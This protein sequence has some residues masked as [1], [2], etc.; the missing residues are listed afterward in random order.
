MVFRPYPVLTLLTLPALALLLALG[1][2]QVERMGWKRDLIA[3]Y[4]TARADPADDL[5]EAICSIEPLPGRPVAQVPEPGGE[6]SVRLYG[7]DGAG[8]PGWRVFRPADAPSCL[9]A[10]AILIETG[11]EPINDGEP[12]DV[13]AWRIERPPEAGPFTPA[14]DPANAEFY[15]FEAAPIAAA[16]GRSS[17]GL[18]REWLL[19]ADDGALPA[20]LSQTPPERHF[21]Y[22]ATW[23]G[24]AITLVAVYLAVHAARGRLRLRDAV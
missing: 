20:R 11:F 9:D 23:F 1:S 2:W 4:E 22:A 19:A 13:T 15:A 10:D 7:R 3:G 14:G 5:S 12:A 17:A 6:A 24:L 8:R 18:S 16:L 21:G